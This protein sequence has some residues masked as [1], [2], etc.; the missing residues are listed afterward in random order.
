MNKLCKWLISVLLLCSICAIAFACGGKKPDEPTIRDKIKLDITSKDAMIETG[1][2]YTLAFKVTGVVDYKATVAVTEKNGGTGFTY[3]EETNAFSATLAG[4]YTLTVTAVQKSNEENKAE[5]SVIVTVTPSM[6]DPVLTIEE[7]PALTVVAGQPL[8]LPAAAAIDYKGEDISADIEVSAMDSRGVTI[9]KNDGVWTLVSNVACTQSVEYFV[10]DENAYEAAEYI[11][12]VVTPVKA[13]TPADP[14]NVIENL[15]ESKGVYVETFADGYNQAYNSIGMQSDIYYTIDATS[16]KMEGNALRVDYKD[17]Y[18]NTNTAMSFGFVEDYWASGKWQIS[19]DCYW[20]KGNVPRGLIHTSL[21]K[22]GQNHGGPT[23][24]L[25]K[26]EVTH[27][28]AE[29]TLAMGEDDV[30][31]FALFLYCPASEE[32]KFTEAG[33][34]DGCVLWIDNIRFEYLTDVNPVVDRSR[35]TPAEFTLDDLS[36]EGI[37]LTGDEASFSPIG[38]TGNPKWV[39]IPHLVDGGYLT[40]EQADNLTSENG[41]SSD[42]AVYHSSEIIR[43]SSFNEMFRYNQYDYT[44]TVKVYLPNNASNWHFFFTDKDYK[45][46][47]ASQIHADDL[48]AGVHTWTFT[49]SGKSTY[50]GFGFY[51]GGSGAAYIGEINVK[52]AENGAAPVDPDLPMVDP[53]VSFNTRPNSGDS[54]AT[55]TDA[56]FEE[57]ATITITHADDNYTALWGTGN[58]RYIEIAKLQE[59]NAYLT[60]SQGA[61]LTPEEGFTSG[62]AIWLNSAGSANAL[63]VGAF[64]NAFTNPEYMYTLTLRVY[65]P[66]TINGYR[67]LVARDNNFNPNNYN[68]E[69]G[70]YKTEELQEGFYTWTLNV[71]G[72]EKNKRLGVVGSRGVIYIGDI[73]VTRTKLLENGYG[74][75]AGSITVLPL[76]DTYKIAT[77]DNEAL[78]SSDFAKSYENAW[79]F[80]KEA[81]GQQSYFVIALG[82]ANTKIAKGTTYRLVLKAFF[83]DG[84]KLGI[85]HAMPNNGGDFMSLSGQKA[86][87]CIVTCI[88]DADKNWGNLVIHNSGGADYDVY[89][90]EVT[91]ETVMVNS[92]Y[93]VLA[94]TNRANP[95]PVT[96]AYDAN[97]KVV[98]TGADDNYTTIYGNGNA[99]YKHI[100]FAAGI[101]TPENGF[102]SG[103]A[104]YMNGKSNPK[105][106]AMGLASF[107]KLFLDP[108]YTHTVTIRV[109]LP[110]GVTGAKVALAVKAPTN[111]DYD[112]NLRGTCNLTEDDMTAGF[113]TWTMMVVGA[114]DNTRLAIT[115]CVGEIYVGDITVTRT[116]IEG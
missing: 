93:P 84:E 66:F 80:T 87:D 35:E 86:G 89:I 11:D 103:Y 27:V 58:A 17:C 39:Y 49:T 10:A 21:V 90:Y 57:N 6:E 16:E 85:T 22:S 24:A 50:Y 94:S 15:E 83:P 2:T 75:K 3:N 60:P 7:H 71:I 92:V 76:A 13:E 29:F 79:H 101:F 61:L 112:N 42:Y 65:V 64:E 62:Y 5:G 69:G 81:M 30:Y 25:T 106:Y 109:Y 33:G 97:D 96:L 108:A 36:G 91:L 107:D 37:T 41:F 100:D 110:N 102:T 23:T 116:L 9:T 1:D 32:D 77:A 115:Q 40:Q 52:I 53:I 78:A 47:G 14:D 98:V 114:A 74:Q 51:K 73:T 34:Y 43:F 70:C 67:L 4:E 55:F 59:N 68:E 88:I 56:S 95:S 82:E 111:S 99:T 28:T 105:Q 45:Q 72:H 19:Y 20:E 18:A 113:H 12:V 48:T 44:V 26:G 63:G 8:A 54:C 46:T 31:V 38:G 104:I